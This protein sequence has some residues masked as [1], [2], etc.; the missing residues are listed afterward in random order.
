MNASSVEPLLT[1]MHA[2]EFAAAKK[3]NKAVNPYL[4]VDRPTAGS[5]Y[6]VKKVV[7]FSELKKPENEE[8][9]DKSKQHEGDN[10]DD[11]KKPQQVPTTLKRPFHV[12]DEEPQIQKHHDSSKP[13][14]VQVKNRIVALGQTSGQSDD[15]EFKRKKVDGILQN[16]IVIINY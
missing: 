14:N 15:K 4:L 3:Q 2:Q 11:S 8:S 7:A 10:Q 6:T 5:R 12:M 1:S 16:E 9:G 13:S